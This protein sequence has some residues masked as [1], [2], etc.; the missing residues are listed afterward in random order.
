MPFA[1]YRIV[2]DEDVQALYAYDY[3]LRV[4]AFFDLQEGKVR[5]VTNYYN[6][7]EWLRQ[8]GA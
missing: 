8:V 2:S 7:E 3:R 1:S 6:L 5:R 4:G